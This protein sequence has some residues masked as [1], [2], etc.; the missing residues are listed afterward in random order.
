MMHVEYL[1]T[2]DEIAAR[3]REIQ[4]TWSDD[5]RLRRRRVRPR[6]DPVGT[7]VRQQAESAL[8]ERIARHRTSRT[9]AG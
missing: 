2:P 5:E 6:T 3:C 8:A 4:A 7:D 1:P 9:R